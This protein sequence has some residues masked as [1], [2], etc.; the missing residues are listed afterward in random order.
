VSTAL[1]RLTCAR[2]CDNIRTRSPVL[3]IIRSVSASV[4]GHTSSS[5]SMYVSSGYVRLLVHNSTVSRENYDTT[6][7]ANKRVLCLRLFGKKLNKKKKK[8]VSYIQIYS[9]KYIQN[10]RNYTF[11]CVCVCTACMQKK[12]TRV[13]LGNRLTCDGT[14]KTK[15]PYKIR[16][17]LLSV[18]T[19]LEEICTNV[20]FFFPR[21]FIVDRLLRRTRR[22]CKYVVQW[23]LTF[24]LKSSIS[25]RL[26]SSVQ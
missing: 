5:S 11:V 24:L 23:N 10:R 16:C 13:S 4:D 9:R 18:I 15:C 21:T 8:H 3:Y 6:A 22:Q 7:C 1:S 14:W 25:Y 19:Y 17:H 12:E 2:Y 20:F 26:P